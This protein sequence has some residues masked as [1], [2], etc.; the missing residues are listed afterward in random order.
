MFLIDSEIPPHSEIFS[1][2]LTR[3]NALITADSE[4]GGS[5]EES[6][7]NASGA[8]KALVSAS[9]MMFAVCGAALNK[10]LPES[11]QGSCGIVI[12]AFRTSSRNKFDRS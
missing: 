5:V 6:S 10:T 4:I 2:R 9:D 8:S 3:F 12:I 11:K 1:Q 7:T